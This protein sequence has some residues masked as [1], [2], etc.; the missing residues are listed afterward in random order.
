MYFHKKRMGRTGWQDP[1]DIKT[2]LTLSW[3]LIQTDFGVRAKPDMTR[4]L[5]KHHR[6]AAV[7]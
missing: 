3:V 5:L 6:R 1:A 7:F 2:Q 4:L